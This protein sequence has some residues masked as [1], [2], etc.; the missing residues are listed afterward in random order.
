MDRG[1]G[2]G[3]NWFCDETLGRLAR[4]LWAAGHD[5]ALAAVGSIGP[6]AMSAA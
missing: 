6:A 5:T 2:Q 3:M 4:L 1:N